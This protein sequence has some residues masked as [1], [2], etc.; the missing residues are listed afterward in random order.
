MTLNR[1]ISEFI[2]FY[3]DKR[4]S[5]N[6]FWIL[7]LRSESRTCD[8]VLLSVEQQSLFLSSDAYEEVVM[9]DKPDESQSICSPESAPVWDLNGRRIRH[10]LLAF[11]ITDYGCSN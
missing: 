10:R 8:L 5:L 11:N 3:R 6:I 9:W 4:S 7:H 1:Q 2:E